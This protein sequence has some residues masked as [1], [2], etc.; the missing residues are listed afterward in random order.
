MGMDPV[1]HPAD[2]QYAAGALSHQLQPDG[3][4][5]N[6][7]HHH[8]TGGY[9]SPHSEADSPDA[10]HERHAASPEGDPNPLR[11]GPRQDIPRDYEGLQGCRRQ[12]RRVLGSPDN[13]NAH[14]HRLV[15]SSGA[16]SIQQTRRSG[17]TVRKNIS[18]PALLSHLRR[19]SIEF[20][21]FVA[22]F[23]R[24]RSHQH[25]NTGFGV[26]FHLGPAK[27]DYDALN[28]SS[29]AGES[30]NDAV[31]DAVANSLLFFYLPK[32]PGPLLDNFEY[33][34]YCHTIFHNR[35]ATSVP[36]VPQSGARSR[37]SPTGTGIGNQGDN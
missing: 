31:D 5:H 10:G 8:S 13:T 11:Q 34:R 3:H 27:D 37:T 22:G 28:G 2:A 15:P 32:R 19:R 6:S 20:R 7:V 16:D 14:S 35:V 1:H 12:P 4:S 18:L 26:C 21:L 30:N 17:R 24:I 23:G 29:T 25:R 33:H 9:P 36:V